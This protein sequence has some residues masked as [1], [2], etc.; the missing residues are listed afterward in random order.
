LLTVAPA[1][2]RPG[3]Q[4]ITSIEEDQYICPWDVEHSPNPVIF[5]WLLDT[6]ETEKEM[7]H[8]S[9]ETLQFMAMSTSQSLQTASSLNAANGS[10]SASPT[11][12]TTSPPDSDRSIDSSNDVEQAPPDSPREVVSPLIIT[13]SEKAKAVS[14]L[15]CDVCQI[16]HETQGQLKYVPLKFICNLTPT[17][18]PL[19]CISTASTVGDIVANTAIRPFR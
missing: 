2:F 9:C 4:R 13:P 12:Y 1:H 6:K 14:S 5:P 10:S 19:A 7:V 15:Q 3:K 11:E 16:I 17:D 8:E 18:Q